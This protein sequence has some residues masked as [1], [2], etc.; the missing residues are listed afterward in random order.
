MQKKDFNYIKN[1]FNF[2][3]DFASLF[4]NKRIIAN[5]VEQD[6]C[7]VGWVVYKLFKDKIKIVK[8]AFS[9][10]D[11]FDFILSKMTTKSVKYIDVNISEYD[12]K[13]QLL[14]K[15][16]GFLALDCIKVNDVY[17]YNFSKKINEFRK[18]I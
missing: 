11:I 2:A 12:L 8:F 13:M 18:D 10:K 6:D 7:I 3:N 5:I 16:N 17:F 9:N 1:N 15:E 14:L 4:R